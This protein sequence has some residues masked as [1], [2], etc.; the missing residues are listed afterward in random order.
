M[1]FLLVVHLNE[2]TENRFASSLKSS[3]QMLF[4]WKE[5]SGNN[6]DC[7]RA[8]QQV[9]KKIELKVKLILVQTILKSMHR[10]S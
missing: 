2:A 3:K 6:A 5:I 8:L 7:F 9:H 1:N 4:I 10:F